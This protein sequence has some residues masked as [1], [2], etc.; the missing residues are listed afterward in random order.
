M[1]PHY[2]AIRYQGLLLLGLGAVCGAVAVISSE[3]VRGQKPAEERV[4]AVSM[5]PHNQDYLRQSRVLR[6][7]AESTMTTAWATPMSLA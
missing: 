4:A 7:L 6:R 1:S 3:E 2:F 5:V